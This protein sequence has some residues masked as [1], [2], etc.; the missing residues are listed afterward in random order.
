MTDCNETP[1]TP[2]TPGSAEFGTYSPNGAD[3]DLWRRWFGEADRLRGEADR[4][5]SALRALALEA[6]EEDCAPDSGHFGAVASACFCSTCGGS[7]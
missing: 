4:A 1:E 2:E 5:L 3:P 6:L 7:P